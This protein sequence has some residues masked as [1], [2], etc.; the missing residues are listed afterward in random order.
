MRWTTKARIQRLLSTAPVGQRLYYTGQRWCGNFKRFSVASKVSQGVACI[1][2]LNSLGEDID[3]WRTVEIGTG[4]TPIIPL[5]FWANGQAECNTFDVTPLLK[6]KLFMDTVTQLAAN[7]LAA[8][9]K[10]ASPARRQE[11]CERIRLVNNSVRLGASAAYALHRCGIRYHPGTDAAHTGL[12]AESADLVFSN[13]V[14]EHVPVAEIDGIFAEACRVLR[15]NGYMA[16]LIDP[17]DHFSH[18]DASISAVNFLRF[19]EE[20]FARYNT[21]FL[22]QNRLRASAWRRLVEQHRFR[23]RIW[24]TT[25]DERA[26]KELPSLKIDPA[27]EGLAPEDLCTTAIWV[28]AQRPP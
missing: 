11:V 15:P 8:V 1:D 13:V 22:H 7:P 2:H 23:I 6:H 18:G 5:V 12:P 28:V 20:A 10:A 9:P 27:F 17:S 14:L 26:L 21:R 3:G 24:E 16:H 19:S 4:W 25:V